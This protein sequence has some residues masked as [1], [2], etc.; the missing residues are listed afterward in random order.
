[1]LANLKL[2]FIYSNSELSNIIDYSK[3]NDMKKSKPIIIVSGLPR[4]GTSLMMQML[5]VGGIPTLSDA[6][7]QADTNNP[8]GYFELEEVKTLEMEKKWL[9][10]AQG[11]AVKII[12]HFLKF[13]PAEHTYKIIM[14][15]RALSNVII[16]QNRMLQQLGKEM[17]P[18][19]DDKLKD[20]Y[21][22]HLDEIKTWLSLQQ[23]IQTIDVVYEHIMAKPETII[24]EIGA[25]LETELNKEVMIQV[26]DHSL[27]HSA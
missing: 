8:G 6:T 2:Y 27:D 7:R 20:I 23:N 12:S 10:D 11:K 24:Q 14:M 4:S 22:L 9:I 5:A 13:L 17:G 18:I 1:V 26:I 3:A 21:Q 25:Y 16:S 19:E 15:K